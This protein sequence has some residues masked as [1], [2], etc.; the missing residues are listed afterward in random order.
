MTTRRT[1]STE[2]KREAVALVQTSGKTMAEVERCRRSLTGAST[3]T[4]RP[5][6]TWITISPDPQTRARC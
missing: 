2:F 5:G 4:C 6:P 3:I 1:Y